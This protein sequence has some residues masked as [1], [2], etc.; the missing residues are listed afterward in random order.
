MT[1][2]CF[3]SIDGLLRLDALARTYGGRPSS[4]AGVS[5]PLHAFWVDEAVWYAAQLEPAAAEDV[6]HA[7]PRE[8]AAPPRQ[9]GD[10]LFGTFVRE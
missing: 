2:P 6:A 1:S 5:E 9:V 4:Y 10:L 7:A 8:R 3:A